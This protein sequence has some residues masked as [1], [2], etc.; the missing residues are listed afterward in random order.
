L[1][2]QFSHFIDMLFWLFGDIKNIEVKLCDFNHKGLTD[3]EDSGFINFDFVNGGSGCLNYSTAVWEE[4]LESSMTIIGQNG[5]VKVGGQYMNEVQ[6][7]NIR[8][9]I[10]PQFV[11]ATL[12]K[13]HGAYTG[14]AANHHFVIEN[15]VNVLKGRALLAVNPED[16]KK[17]VEIIQKIYDQAK[18]RRSTSLNKE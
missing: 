4:N 3:F 5:T 13:E 11:P 16:A 14:S 12:P 18:S 1:F 6:L 2:T 15:V 9:Y 10:M 7:C 17:A 8:G